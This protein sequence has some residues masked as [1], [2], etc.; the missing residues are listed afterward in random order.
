[1]RL[2]A[3][4]YA[5]SVYAMNRDGN[6]SRAA[7]ATFPVVSADLSGLSV[8][9][10]PWQADKHQGLPITFTNL[11]ADA[12][13]KI[14]STSGQWVKTLS[15]ISGNAIWYLKNED[16]DDVASGLYFYLASDH[17]SHKRGK[18]AVIK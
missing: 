10:N 12:T 17:D 13:I 18:L 14:F 9:P 11:P 3:G 15:S 16:N 1:M 6:V 5:V 8:F 4:E 2:P 7:Q